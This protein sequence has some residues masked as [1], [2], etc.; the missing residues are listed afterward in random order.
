MFIIMLCYKQ[1]IW[2][3]FRLS[4]INNYYIAIITVCI[5]RISEPAF[6]SSLTVNYSQLTLSLHNTCA[7]SLHV[8]CGRVLWEVTHSGVVLWC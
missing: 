3:T 4:A 2:N 6:P 1:N 7:E 8:R 5:P